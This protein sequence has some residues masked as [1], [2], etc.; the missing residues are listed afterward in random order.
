MKEV[1]GILEDMEDLEERIKVEMSAQ[2][3][4]WKEDTQ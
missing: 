1:K 3:I 4:R 2:G